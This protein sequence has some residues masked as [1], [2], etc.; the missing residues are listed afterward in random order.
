MPFITRNCIE[1]IRQR[2]NLVDVASSYTQMRKAGTHWRGLSPFNAERTPSFYVQP[3]KNV[4]KCYSSGFAGDLF[5]FVELKEKLNFNEAAQLLAERF[6]IPLE[7]EEGRG[8]HQS[9]SLRKELLEIQELSTQFFHQSLIAKTDIAQQAR[10]YW[11]HERSFSLED[12]QK[13]Q[14]GFSPVAPFVLAE[15]LAKFNFPYEALVE[16]GLFYAPRENEQS[17]P[18]RLRSRFRGR[19]MIPIRD[20]HGRVVAFSG[21]KTPCTPSDDPSHEAKYVNSPETQLFIKGDLLFGLHEARN[22]V[23]E[24]A[25]I[26]AEGQLDVLRLWQHGVTSAVAPQG[27]SITQAQLELMRR[28]TPSVF[29]VMD[30]DAAGQRA[31][32]RVLPMALAAGLEL[33]FLSLPEGEDPDSLLVKKG[34]SVWEEYV[35]KA[36]SEM[37]FAIG[38]LAP[39]GR[40]SNARVKEEAFQTVLGYFKEVPSLTLAQTHLT[41]AA[42]L[43]GLYEYVADRAIGELKRNKYFAPKKQEVVGNDRKDFAEPLL[44]EQI[45]NVLTHHESFVVKMAELIDSNWLQKDTLP[46]L[47]L[48]RLLAATRE[49][50]F[51]DFSHSDVFVQTQAEKDCLHAAMAS[52]DSFGA[53]EVVRSLNMLLKALFTRQCELERVRLSGELAQTNDPERIRKIHQERIELRKMLQNPPCLAI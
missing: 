49:G 32:L 25:F 31:A 16:S 3:E 48:D 6:N 23:E 33:R 34:I 43:L 37:E 26:L 14:I 11:T 22:H 15:H 10:K 4:F 19:L 52:K 12:A 40:R 17:E 42:N 53:E 38:V 47:I 13:W 18:T 50:L 29:C 36:K 51:V 5:R 21:R 9:R 39:E 28:Y 35:E 7:F 30:G 2:V 27:T 46:G 1:T 41:A 20:I 45:L 44:E 24:R 8:N